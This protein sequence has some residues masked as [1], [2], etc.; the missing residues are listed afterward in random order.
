MKKNLESE[1]RRRNAD[2]NANNNND[3]GR[4]LTG[5]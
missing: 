5:N 2:R 1:F 3:L 4:A